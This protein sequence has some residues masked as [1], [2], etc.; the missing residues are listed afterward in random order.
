MDE[1]SRG[2][3]WRNPLIMLTLTSVNTTRTGTAIG[4]LEGTISE[5]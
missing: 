1:Y 4:D 2:R 3:S 5:M